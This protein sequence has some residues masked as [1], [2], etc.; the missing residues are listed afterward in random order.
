MDEK[1]G[2]GGDRFEEVVAEAN[3]CVCAAFGLASLLAVQHAP[4][5]V[6]SL[7]RELERYRRLVAE[8]REIHRAGR[9][10]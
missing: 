3:N 10:E 6:E 4:E 7:S 2:L 8:L 5:F 9:P 1:T